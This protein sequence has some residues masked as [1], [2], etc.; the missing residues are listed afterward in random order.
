M[1]DLIFKNIVPPHVMES[2]QILFFAW[3]A[4]PA[5]YLAYNHDKI[6]SLPTGP[7][8]RFLGAPA[9]TSVEEFV[10]AIIQ[11]FIPGVYKYNRLRT[12]L[13]NKDALVRY[14]QRSAAVPNFYAESRLFAAHYGNYFRISR[15]AILWRVV[16]TD[17]FSLAPFQTNF[18]SFT[19]IKNKTS[20]YRRGK[21]NAICLKTHFS[22]GCILLP[23]KTIYST[24][25][26]EYILPP[27]DICPHNI[28]IL[29]SVKKNIFL[30]VEPI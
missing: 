1:K 29:M 11:E 16:V 5:L 4:R 14:L 12:M 21:K 6:S 18:T 30:A 20:Y 9:R 19:Q 10:R 2:F 27:C 23:I 7:I 17:H 15:P 26:S 13:P 24:T 8:D 22:P 25:Q 28:R 3:D